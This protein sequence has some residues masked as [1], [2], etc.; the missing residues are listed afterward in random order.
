MFVRLSFLLCAATIPVAASAQPVH[1]PLCAATPDA[2]SHAPAGAQ[3]EAA[4]AKR[5]LGR[6]E[7]VALAPGIVVANHYR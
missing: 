6:S 5:G 4:L 1:H 7:T 3:L 2:A